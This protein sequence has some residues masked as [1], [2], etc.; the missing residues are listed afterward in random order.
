MRDAV[1]H[2]G[3]WHRHPGFLAFER[4]YQVLYPDDARRFNRPTL[5]SLAKMTRDDVNSALQD[6]LSPSGAVGW[7]CG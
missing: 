3:D 6:L 4:M 5:E 1:P 2:R 7:N